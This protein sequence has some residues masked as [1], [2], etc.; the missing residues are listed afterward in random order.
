MSCLPTSATTPTSQPPA[1]DSLSISMS[2][3][4]NQGIIISLVLSA[5]AVVLAIAGI[6]LL[7][8]WL[9]IY[10]VL[11]AGVAFIIS[12]IYLMKTY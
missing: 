6:A 2:M 4:D 9:N 10:A 5:I 12:M 8:L 1:K 3:T 11:I 7:I